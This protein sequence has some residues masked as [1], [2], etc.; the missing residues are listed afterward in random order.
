MRNAQ[1]LAALKEPGLT[2]S[3]VTAKQALTNAR[4]FQELLASVRDLVK[5]QALQVALTAVR[6]GLQAV[7]QAAV[8]AATLR[9]VEALIY[10]HR[11]LKL[12][13]PP[14]V[15]S[16]ALMLALLVVHILQ[17]LYFAAR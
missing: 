4:Q 6:E 12:W 8:A 14:H 1:L 3:F 10:L 16:S 7:E 9:R 5:R 17:V 15:A 11:L 2:E 13:L